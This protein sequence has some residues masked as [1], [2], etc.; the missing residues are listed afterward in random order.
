MSNSTATVYTSQRD[1]PVGLRSAGGYPLLR[2]ARDAGH[3]PGD[4]FSIRTT[5]L[6]GMMTQ[7]LRGTPRRVQQLLNDP[8]EN[9]LQGQESPAQIGQGD[10]Q[11]LFE[12]TEKQ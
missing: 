12:A 7:N 5:Q 3:S 6:D 1:T 4:G 10:W 8:S 2:E 9:P 11:A